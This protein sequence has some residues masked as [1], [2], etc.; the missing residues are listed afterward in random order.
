MERRIFALLAWLSLLLFAGRAHAF[1]VEVL[2]DSG[3]SVNRVDIVILGDGYREEDQA[4]LTADATALMN[5]FLGE[6]IYDAYQDYYNFTL[7]HV[8]SNETGADM[9]SDGD[10]RDTALGATYFC[11]GVTERLLCVDSATAFGVAMTDAP[12]FDQI[13]V[14]VNDVKYGGSGGSLAVTSIAPAAGDIAIHEIGHSLVGLADEY[15]DEAFTFPACDPTND[16]TEP[17]VTLFFER[18]TLKWG[19]WVEDTTPL[20]TPNEPE[21]F[22]VVGAFEGARYLA[23]GVYRPESNCM[24][25]ALG[26]TLC[27]VCSEAGVLTT[28]DFVSPIDQ[29]LPAGPVAMNAGDSVDFTIVGP[30]PMPQTLS[31]S[32]LIDGV[33]FAVNDT[34]V[35]TLTPSDFG[36][37]SHTLTVV[38]HDDTT[39]VRRDDDDVLTET[40]TWQVEVE[41]LSTACLLGTQTVDLRD[42]A[43]IASDVHAGS[44]TIGNQADIAG[45]VFASGDGSLGNSVIQGDATLGGTLVGDPAGV[46]GTLTE[47]AMVVLPVLETQSFAVGTGSQ[48]VPNDA[49]VTLAEGTYGNMTFRARSSVTL[50]GTYNF[51]SLNVEPD[52]EVVAAGSASVNVQGAL[53]IGDRASTAAEAASALLFYTNGAFTRIGTDVELTGIVVAPTSAVHVYSRTSIVGCIGGAQVTFEPD[54]AMDAAGVTLPTSGGAAGTCPDGM[55]NGSETGL[56]C[57]GPACPACPNGQGCNQSSDCMSGNCS[58]GVCVAGVPLSASLVTTADWG[59]GYC[60]TLLVT[61]E[62]TVPTSTWSVT[63]DTNQ[64]SIYTSWNGT[65]TGASGAISVAPGF[66]WNQVIPPGATN[67]SVGFCA[68]RDV[69]GSGTLPFVLSA[70]G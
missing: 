48:E 58:G 15:V 2:K 27:R 39:L 54:V 17:N 13:M 34:G 26:L 9:G 64:S 40:F 53:E 30:R 43:L 21:F 46:L 60:V 57:G 7:V 25:R 1:D 4:Q 3:D 69:P 24:M 31:F 50:S 18:S 63:L 51:A 62:G 38:I 59:G 33:P 10:M 42:R 55:Q 20:P 28:Y 37:G 61:N 70:G 36:L 44:F 41:S 11:D 49:I 67:D 6:P 32:W 8:I 35:L 19:L 16:C 52:V 66:F 23:T 47:G 14:V 68:N 56:D 5:Q 22:D 45:S 29:A 65:F 12:G